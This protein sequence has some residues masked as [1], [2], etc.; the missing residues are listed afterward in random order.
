MFIGLANYLGRF[1]PHLATVAGPLRDLCKTNIPCD[2]EPEHDAAFSNLKKAIPPQ[3]RCFDTLTVQSHSPVRVMLRREH[4]GLHCFKPMT[5]THS[6]VSCCHSLTE[7]ESRYPNIEC[8]MLCIVFGLE[9]FHKY[10]TWKCIR[11]INR[12]SPS[13]PNISSLPHPRWHAC[14]SAYMKYVPSSDAKLADALSRMN[15]CNTGPM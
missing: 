14:Y 15:P 6:S 1:T 7:T 10:V 13:T 2:W 5:P 3:I 4:S 8:E 11:T 9:R 12:L